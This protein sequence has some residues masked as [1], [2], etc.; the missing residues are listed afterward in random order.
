MHGNRTAQGTFQLLHRSFSSKNPGA[1]V[2]FH[3]NPY[4]LFRCQG[5]GVLFKGLIWDKFWHCK[6]VGVLAVEGSTN[7][8]LSERSQTKARS[9]VPRTGAARA[10]CATQCSPAPGPPGWCWPAGG[11]AQ[12]CT[13]S[14]QMQS[15]KL[16]PDPWGYWESCLQ[17]L[18]THSHFYKPRFKMNLK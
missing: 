4:F 18:G 15:S 17:A 5:L 13:S 10:A 2:L 16:K 1:L 3:F 11:A 12:L 14:P 9:D 7:P 8:R 6:F